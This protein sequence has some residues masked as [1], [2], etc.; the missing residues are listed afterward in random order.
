VSAQECEIG[1][2]APVQKDLSED[3]V[4]IHRL[5][6]EFRV[7]SFLADTAS[8]LEFHSDSVTRAKIMS[9]KYLR[10]DWGGSV[11]GREEG[12]YRN[13][14]VKNIA[15]DGVFSKIYDNTAVATY[16]SHC[17]Y[18]DARERYFRVVRV[19][20]KEDG[21]WKTISGFGYPLCR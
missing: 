6:E 5:I 19:F 15:Y 14:A 18:H 12:G 16:R 2:L 3:Q 9:A 21:E 13:A 4:S 10:L 17:W 7:A 8:D 1:Q 20:Q 11:S